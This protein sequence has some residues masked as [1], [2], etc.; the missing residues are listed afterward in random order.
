MTNIE[1]VDKFL[2]EAKVFYFLTS[3]DNK[4]KGRPFSFHMIVD[5]KLYFGCGTFKDCYKQ[6]VENENVEILAT[7]NGEFLRYDGKAKVVEDEAL[8]KKVRE[9]MPDIMSLYDKNNWV[10][11]LFYLTEAHAEI[12]GLFEVKEEFDL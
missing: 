9:I 8:I 2:T 4:P 3:T 12:R 11:G 5:D 6:L 10:M 7:K 1:K